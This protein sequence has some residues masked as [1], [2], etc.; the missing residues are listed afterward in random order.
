MADKRKPEDIMHVVK[1]VTRLFSDPVEC[2]GGR[3]IQFRGDGILALFGV[4]VERDDDAARA[5]RAGLD[6][7][8]N[9]ETF[10]PEIAAQYGVGLSARIG[11]NTG[12]VVVGEMGNPQ[13]SVHTAMGDA[14]NMAERMQRTA[15]PGDIVMSE[16]TYQQVR[17]L[18]RVRSLGATQVKG[19]LEPVRAYC[20]LG[21]RG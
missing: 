6:M 7:Q 15:D 18:F 2:H 16:S 8:H 5:V 9:L 20:V 19:K 14:V 11:L 1:Q 10:G 3:V 21:E 17:G 13:H 12:V 4:P